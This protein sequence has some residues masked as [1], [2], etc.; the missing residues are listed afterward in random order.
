[1][2]Q[3]QLDRRAYWYK[4]QTCKLSVNRKTSLFSKYYDKTLLLLLDIGF[5]WQ[6]CL[7]DVHSWS[8]LVPAWC[9]CQISQ[10]Q[11]LM[12]NNHSES[13]GRLLATYQ[14]P[15][16]RFWLIKLAGSKFQQSAI[17]NCHQF[18]TSG[19]RHA[20]MLLV[21]SKFFHTVTIRYNSPVPTILLLSSVL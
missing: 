21:I 1:M 19:N 17:W 8:P 5:H 7:I 3:S 13:I 15:I 14:S 16:D 2:T 11:V 20:A 6:N 9:W 12:I 18:N 10:L 4:R